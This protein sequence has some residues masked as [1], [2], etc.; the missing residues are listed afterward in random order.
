MNLHNWSGEHWSKGGRWYYGKPQPQ[1]TQQDAG[2]EFVLAEPIRTDRVRF[3][4]ADGGPVR[5]MELRLFPPSAAGYPG[6]FPSKLE[7][8]PEVVD[9]APNAKLE[10]SSTMEPK[11]AAE[12]AVDGKLTIDS[13]W[14]SDKRKGPHHL[15]LSFAAPQTIGCIQLVSGWP[16]GKSWQGIVSDFQFEY[17]TGTEWLPVP[18][19]S[20][21]AMAPEPVIDPDHDLGKQ[22]H[23]Y[24]LEWNEDELIY[25]FDG[26]EIRRQAHTI[27]RGPAHVFLSLAIIRWAGAVTDAVDGTSMDVDYVRIW[28]R[29]PQPAQQ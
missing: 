18:G 3:T 10:A 9:L 21:N 7:A 28:Q 11:Y 14:L 16:D 19:A 12:N 2:F 6:V 15:T 29:E 27:C 24:G 13:R 8:Q 5:V 26:Q 17:W 1:P 22:F 25:F 4:S 23:T 20:R